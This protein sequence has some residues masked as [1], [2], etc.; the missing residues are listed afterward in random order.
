MAWATQALSEVQPRT[1]DDAYPPARHV[2]RG[3]YAFLRHPIYVGAVFASGGSA[4]ALGS[5][6]GL[7][8]VTPLVAALATAW[9]LGF[10]RSLT[11]G[12]FGATPQPWLHLPDADA[13]SASRGERAFAYTHLFLP[14]L[15]LSYGV[16]SLVVP[17]DA[18]EAWT[19]WDAAWPVVP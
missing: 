16:E 2:T 6:A 11:R 1:P 13:V 9:V 14:W 4:L 3:P 5:A 15:V 8:I 19:R 17:H 10:E 18:V 12:R 7:R